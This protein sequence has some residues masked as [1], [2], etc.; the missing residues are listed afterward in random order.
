MQDS[1]GGMATVA[2]LLDGIR[3]GMVPR[4][5]RLFAAQGLLPVGREDL[6][7]LLVLLAAD[8]D[9]EISGASRATLG[10]FSSENFLGVLEF[11]DLQPLEID[12]L[13]RSVQMEPVWEA[14]IR[15]AS[16]ADETLRWLGRNGGPRIQDALIT[17]QVRLLTCLEILED[18][19][20]NSQ[21]TPETLRRVR[22]FEEEFLEKA[23]L[24]ASGVEEAPETLPVVSI[25]EA[26][27]ALRE[28]GMQI[29]GG[30]IRRGEVPPEPDESEPDEIRDAF[31]RLAL[32]NAHEKVMTAVK[33]TREE[34]MILVRDRSLLVV[35]AVMA[36][37]KMNLGDVE[38]IA[39]MRTA[40]DE[41]LRLIARRGAWI[42]RYGVVR[43]L[44][45]NPRTPTATALQLLGRLSVRDMGLLSKDRGVAEAVRRVARERFMNRR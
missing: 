11:K 36:S 28:I 22:E 9:E 6:I 25:D 31:V 34:R 32:M 3:R 12:L 13:A 2:Q 26:L 43:N 40:N 21:A 23:V 39:G 30:E 16:T 1:G 4:N 44:A 15:H 14:I 8:G 19:R 42:R 10:T 29:P 33:G 45:F 27:A 24:W 35:R 17:N 37:P 5:V 20:A 18:L 41:A 38:Q 7:R